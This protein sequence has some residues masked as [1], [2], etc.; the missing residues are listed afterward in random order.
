MTTFD[1]NNAVEKAI[2]I[3]PVAAYIRVS[4]QEQKMHGISLDAQMAKLEEYAKAHNMKIVEWYKDEGVSGRKLIKN[5]P[6]MQRMIQD[7]EKGR[8]ERIIFV[9]LDRFFRSTAEYHEAMKRIAP[10]TWTATEEKY[11]LTTAN[12]RMLVNAKLM[13]AELEADLAGERV[14]SVNE[15]KVSTGQP[16]SGSQPISHIIVKDSNTGRKKIVRNPEV[17]DILRDVFA[18][19][20]LHQSKHKAVLYMKSV[21]HLSMHYNSFTNLLANTMLYGFYRGNPN[22]CEPYM[23]KEE[24]EKM[25]EIGEKNV[26]DN[27]AENRAFFFSG[28]ILC[29]ACGKP[30]KG[31]TSY[32][33]KNGREYRYKRYRCGFYQMSR[34]CTFGKAILEPTMEKMMLKEIEH[35]LEN[36]KIASSE[37]KDSDKAR[38]KKY[39]ID[40]INEQIDRLNYSWTSGKIRKVE[41]YDKDHAELMKKLM[42]AEAELRNAPV[43]DYSRIE[44][45]L[46]SGWRE[47]YN[48]LDDEHKRAFWRSF[49]SSIEIEW[50]TKTKKI[51]KV[52]FF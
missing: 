47:I 10:V 42:A 39:D 44:G 51:K 24:F 38:M 25:Q 36:A 5:R 40:E 29:P 17:E 4:S 50:T 22:Y 3:E 12:G 2:R 33:E 11:D 31:G 21:H 6:E 37:V 15:Y 23:T 20:M 9:K 16:L 52:N 49:I 7:A 32:Q 43:T 8:F 28:L 45:I 46:Q 1:K 26:K 14:S 48:A 41:Q 18:H 13:V 19:Y 34:K 30:L 35:H 27:T